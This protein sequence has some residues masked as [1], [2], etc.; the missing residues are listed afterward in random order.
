MDIFQI[1][2]KDF[3]EFHIQLILYDHPLNDK[4]FPILHLKV[5]SGWYL[6]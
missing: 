6:D 5:I 4:H 3:T 1:H 2:F